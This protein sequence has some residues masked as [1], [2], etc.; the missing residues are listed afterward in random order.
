MDLPAMSR[1]SNTYF[2][3]GNDMVFRGNMFPRAAGIGN[4]WTVYVGKSN[5][6]TTR[7]ETLSASRSTRCGIKANRCDAATSES[8]IISFT[9]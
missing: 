9:A 6:S 5:N 8:K 3:T 4:K 2:D 7:L 1:R